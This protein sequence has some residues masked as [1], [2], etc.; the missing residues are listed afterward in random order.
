M[1]KFDSLLT[2]LPGAVELSH[3]DQVIGLVEDCRGP[4]P[5]CAAD[6]PGSDAST[7]ATALDGHGERWRSQLILN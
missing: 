3:P 4:L 1:E 7:E 2:R 6:G 5:S